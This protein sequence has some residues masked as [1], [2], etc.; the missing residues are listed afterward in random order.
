MAEK[1]IRIGSSENILAYDDA[2]FSSAMETDQPIKAGA[3]IDGNDVLRKD[4]VLAI[5]VDLL[6]PIGSLYISTLSTNPHTLLGTG[7]WTSFGA[8]RV[9]VGL[10]AA[11]ADFD[12]AEEIGGAKTSTPDAHTGT[13]V[14]A[15]TKEANKQGAAAGDVVTTETHTV[16]QPNTHAAMSIVQP[17]IVV[18]MWKR[19]A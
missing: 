2:D 6:Y 14:N 15:H 9:L 3:P 17:Y 16:T 19:T 8:G 5:I 10:N 13:A 1:F 11:D 4:D 18:Y 12:T 7:T